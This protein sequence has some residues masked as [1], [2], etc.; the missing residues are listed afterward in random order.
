M[1][2]YYIKLSDARYAIMDYIGEQTVSKYASAA[3]CKLARDGAEGALNALDYM[4]PADVVPKSEVEA[5]EREIEILK[6]SM[7]PSYYS[8]CS[9]EEAIK[10]GK[11]YGGAE[12]AREIF[13]DLKANQI[14]CVSEDGAVFF[15]IKS[16]TFK[17]LRKK[18]MRANDEV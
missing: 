9:E 17:Q 1:Y 2:N 18:H 3:D 13:N 6:K 12:V 4:P 8:A 15:C 14:P 5:L 16:K 7:L 11:K 10:I